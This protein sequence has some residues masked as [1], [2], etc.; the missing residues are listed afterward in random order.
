M[1]YLTVD[2]VI[3]LHRQIMEQAGE[4]TTIRDFGLLDSAVAQPQM[5][6]GGQDLYPSIVEKASALCFSLNKNHAFQDGNKRISHAA[7]EAFL[8]LNGFEVDASVDEQEAII[9]QVADGQ[10]SREDFTEWLQNSI[11]PKGY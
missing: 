2:E 3:E 5:T 6:Y 7:M 9:L 1:R 10:L 4:D 11:V 8:T